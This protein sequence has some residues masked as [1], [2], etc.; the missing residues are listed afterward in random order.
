MTHDAY[1]GKTGRYNEAQSSRVDSQRTQLDAILDAGLD[2]TFPASDPVA[3]T[4]ALEREVNPSNVES[5][6][7]HPLQA[8]TRATF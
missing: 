4:P 5:K 1:S 8:R 7:D 2:Q 6:S 3:L